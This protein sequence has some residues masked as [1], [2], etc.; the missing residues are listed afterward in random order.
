MTDP[1]S[2]DKQNGDSSEAGASNNDTGNDESAGK[3]TSD[4]GVTQGSSPTGNDTEA[5]DARPTEP[6][7]SGGTAKRG[8]GGPGWIALILAVGALAVAALPYILEP[9]AEQVE[10]DVEAFPADDG[11]ALVQRLDAIEG[12]LASAASDARSANDDVQSTADAVASEFER[13]GDEIG[14]LNEEVEALAAG[15]DSLRDASSSIDPLIERVGRLEG[16]QSS[17]EA[18]LEARMSAL[19]ERIEQRVESM[20]QRLGSLGADLE[21]AGRDSARRLALIHA[22]ALLIQGRDR[23]E[24]AGDADGAQAAWRRAQRAV[25]GEAVPE[26]IGEAIERLV[27]AAAD[28]SP[29]PVAERVRALDGLARGAIDWPAPLDDDVAEREAPSAEDE[30]GWRSRM[31]SAM[32]RLVRVE[33]IDAALPNRA[34]VDQARERIHAALSAAA[35]AAAREDWSTAAAMVER[36]RYTVSEDLVRQALERMDA[37]MEPPGRPQLPAAY[38]EAQAAVAGA[39]E[40]AR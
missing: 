38:E 11:R 25:Q 8:G 31:A 10:S 35:V 18:S 23:L 33:S 13:L 17:A 3:A 27:V 29:V 15:Q 30:D 20:Q 36:A 1:K 32:G 5:R 2:G 16:T 39:L 6:R 26:R 34:E 22:R 21:E 14:A 19:E 40:A 4:D 24:L 9:P 7:G 37:L 12:E 28:L